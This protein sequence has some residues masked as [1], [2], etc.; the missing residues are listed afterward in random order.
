MSGAP[1]GEMNNPSCLRVRKKEENRFPRKR[2]EKRE[3]SPFS[4]EVDDIQL[5]GG[6][7]SFSYL[8]RAKPFKTMVDPVEVKINQFS[9]GKEKKATYALAFKTEADEK[10]DM[11]GQLSMIRFLLRAPS[12]LTESV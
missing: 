4:V 5:T 11:A 10:I 1:R 9:N 3:S 7:V 2:K 6:K 8:S 12:R